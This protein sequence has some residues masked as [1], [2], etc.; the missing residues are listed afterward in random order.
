MEAFAQAAG[1]AGV[2]VTSMGTI[3]GGAAVPRFLDPQ[4]REIVLQR[5]SYSHF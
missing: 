3:I 4:G 2:A 1:L 5:R